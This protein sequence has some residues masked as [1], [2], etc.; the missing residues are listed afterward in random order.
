MK[1]DVIYEDTNEKDSSP[2]RNKCNDNNV[3]R[4][5][6]ACI[7]GL[8]CP[9]AKQTRFTRNEYTEIGNNTKGIMSMACSR[10]LLVA[11]LPGRIGGRRHLPVSSLADERRAAGVALEIRQAERAGSASETKDPSGWLSYHDRGP[12]I[13]DR[14][15]QRGWQTACGG[16]SLSLPFSSSS[17]IYEYR[18]R[19]V[20]RSGRLYEDLR[21]SSGVICFAGKDKRETGTSSNVSISASIVNRNDPAFRPVFSNLLSSLP[22]PFAIFR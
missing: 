17:F 15:R 3:L 22:I 10:W 18:S 16:K 8:E 14:V 13:G 6:W 5:N 2:S 21:T 4:H 7:H 12:G 1:C 9:S 19:R 20:V 11:Y